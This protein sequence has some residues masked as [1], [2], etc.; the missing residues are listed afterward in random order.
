MIIPIGYAQVT[1]TYGGS[2]LPHGAANTYG[3][4]LGGGMAGEELAEFLHTQWTGVWPSVGD[5]N[6]EMR[7]TIVKYG[8]NDVGPVFEYSE[9]IS[10]SV[11]GNGTP[12]NTAILVQ[13]VTALGGRRNRGRIYLPAV[14]NYAGTEQGQLPAPIVTDLN[15]RLETWQDALG[16]ADYLTYLFHSGSSDPTIISTWRA[17]S[18][19]ATQRRRLRR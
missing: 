18:T 8:P 13:K 7:S 17:T 2:P 9:V 19:Y 4:S 5:S 12:P 15:D 1:H 3:I 16:A 11:S 14:T 6:A 10:G